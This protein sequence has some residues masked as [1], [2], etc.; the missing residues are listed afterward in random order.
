M[1]VRSTTPPTRTIGTYYQL[2]EIAIFVVF[3][4][5][6]ALRGAASLENHW[7]EACILLL[8]AAGSQSFRIRIS[9]VDEKIAF[10]MAA[11]I[12]GLALPSVDMLTTVMVWV[13]GL[14]IGAV[15]LY[16]DLW[17]AA[18]IGGR[19]VLVGLI[20]A[21]TT[22]LL[23]GW[24]APP[25]VSIPAATVAYIAVSLLLWRLPAILF[26]ENEVISGAIPQ[27]ILLIFG[28]NA[29]IPVLSHYAELQAFGRSWT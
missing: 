24:G 28:L 6:C 17:M 21:S 20:Y 29:T 3:V 26:D 18:K 2:G 1:A 25:V 5:S 9:A 27:R 12:L 23:T 15:V 11:G 16:R 7:V 4:I 10:G 22:S 13:T 14:A 8:C 19:Q